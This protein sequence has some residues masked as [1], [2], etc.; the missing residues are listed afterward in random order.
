MNNIKWI[1]WDWGGPLATYSHLSNK[2]IAEF[3]NSTESMVRKAIY[4]NSMCRDEFMNGN[5]SPVQ[6]VNMMNEYFKVSSKKNATRENF[7]EWM[8]DEMVV[9]DGVPE[10][11]KELRYHTCI[12]MNGEDAIYRQN[13]KLAVLSNTWF[14]HWDSYVK[15]EL[16]TF[17]DLN[18]ASHELGAL[19]PDPEIY[20]LACER[21]QCKPEEVVFF[22]DKEENVKGA[23][24]FGMDAYIFTSV[25]HARNILKM[26]EIL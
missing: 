25:Q 22:D 8:K 4:N 5:Y 11:I 24:D 1:L 6:F 17:F 2:K 20:K 13:F 10:L 26:L 7:V 18:M 12:D 3:Y 14:A 23:A 9:N 16:A 15:S 19:K 21:M